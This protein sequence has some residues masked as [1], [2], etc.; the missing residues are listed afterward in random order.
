M[1]WARPE[2][3]TMVKV[4]PPW[5]LLRLPDLMH[6]GDTQEKSRQTDTGTPHHP[7][8]FSGWNQLRALAWWW[9]GLSWVCVLAFLLPWACS[10]HRRR[11][12]AAEG[13]WP[14]TRL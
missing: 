13:P 8:R 9:P 7:R 1:E 6:W 2:S 12:G 14:A 3:G 4:F 10:G 11:P 5:C